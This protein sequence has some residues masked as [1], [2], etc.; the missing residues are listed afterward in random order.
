[1]SD[2]NANDWM[3]LIPGSL[4]KEA[5]LR[6]KDVYRCIQLASAILEAIRARRSKI[7]LAR[8]A[9]D[10]ADAIERVAQVAHDEKADEQIFLG[11]MVLIAARTKRGK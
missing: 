11:A 5:G 3:A 7:R 6:K 1:M 8:P 10:S 2:A 9:A 4:L